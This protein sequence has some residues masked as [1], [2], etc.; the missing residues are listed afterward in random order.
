VQ[1]EVRDRRPQ[2]AP[3]A[4]R[5]ITGAA[6]L[7]TLARGGIFE[8]SVTLVAGVAGSGKSILGYQVAVEG[9]TQLQQRSLLATTDEHPAQILRHAE[10]LGLEMR[11]QVEAGLIEIL[12]TSP[13]ELEA[14]VYYDRICHALEAPPS[15]R[16]VLDGL[17]TLRNA[18]HDERRFREFIHGLIAFTK[19]R[20]ITTFLCYESPEVFGLSRFLPESGVSSLVDNILLLNLV[21]LGS[22]IHRAITAVKARGHAHS[23]VTREFTIGAGGITLVPLQDASL[24]DAVPFHQYYNVLSRAP[25][26]FPRGDARAD[27]G[28][29]TDPA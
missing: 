9:A 17:T 5:S 7:D 18:L 14:D 4:Q 16:L 23:L 24:P 28:A 11:A 22:Q 6:A 27:D 20:L 25:T 19:E 3:T 1:A 13:L 29:A 12:H 10:A 26:R 15:A 21:E 8:G 2:P